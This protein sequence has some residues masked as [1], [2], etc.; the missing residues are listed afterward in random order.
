MNEIL[1][2]RFL[3]R[4]KT[5]IETLTTI[6]REMSARGLLNS[7]ATVKRGHDALVSEFVGSRKLISST[8]AEILRITKPT[9]IQNNLVHEATQRLEDRRLYLEQLYV[10]QMKSIIGDLL[11]K[12]SLEPYT[13]LGNVIDLNLKELE[14]ELS[15][16]IDAYLDYRGATYYERI[17]NQFLDRPLVVI[18]VITITAVSAIIAFIKVLGLLEH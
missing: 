13:N 4:D 9:K 2:L 3:E 16:V 1:R 8:S 7:G 17:K 15:H 14:I 5:F 11:N 10:E 18:A 12:T 6:K